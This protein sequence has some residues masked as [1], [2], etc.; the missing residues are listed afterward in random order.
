MEAPFEYHGRA[1]T[2]IGCADIIRDGDSV[3]PVADDRPDRLLCVA[4]WWLVACELPP[5]GWVRPARTRINLA[6]VFHAP[7]RP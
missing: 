1:E 5:P 4:C 6:G 3:A 2:C 7:R